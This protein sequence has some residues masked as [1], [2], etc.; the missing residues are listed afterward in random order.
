M[1]ARGGPRDTCTMADYSRLKSI[2]LDLQAHRQSPPSSPAEDRV[3]QKRFLVEN[4]FK[5]LDINSD[6]HLSS[7]ELAQLMKK[8]DL[9]DDLLDCTLED[10][11]RFDDYNND[12]RLTLQELYTA[13]H[14][15]GEVE[16]IWALDDS[17]CGATRNSPI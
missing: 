11:L 14:L 6:G 5:H 7:S 15:D 12:G 13:F 8:E 2:L 3:S 9:E 16:Q 4:M 17:S 10:L 1:P